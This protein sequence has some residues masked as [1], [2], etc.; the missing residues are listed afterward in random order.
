MENNKENFYSRQIYTYGYETMKNL[1]KLKVLIFGLRGL[2]MEI[3]KNLILSGPKEIYL[4]DKNIIT[5][6]DLG[7]GYYFSE[8]KVNKFCRDEGCI[9]QLSKL[10]SFVEVKILND[11][12]ITALNNNAFNIIIITE[13]LEEEKLY[14]INEICRKNNIGFIYGCT[15][16]LIGFIFVDFGNDFYILNKY[17]REPKTFYINN[18]TNEENAV[19]TVDPA[20]IQDKFLS[21]DSYIIISEVKGMSEINKN[22]PIKVIAIDNNKIS[23]NINTSC[24]NKYING[25]IIKEYFQ[26]EEKNYQSLKY[27]LENPICNIEDFKEDE[28]TCQRH[29]L[30]VGIHKYFNKYKFL[31]EFNNLNQANE[32]FQFSKEYFERKKLEQNELFLEKENLDEDICIN[33]SKWLRAELPPYCNFFGGIMSQEV[34]KYTGKYIPLEQWAWFDFYDTVRNIKNTNRNLLNSRYDEQI[35]IYGL[36]TQKK[37]NNLNIFMIGAGALGCEYLKLFSMMGIANNKNKKITV[38]DNDNIEISNLNRQFLFKK[39]HLGKSK[40]KIACEEIKKMNKNFN[41]EAHQNLVNEDTEII[42]DENFWKSQDI[43]INAVDNNEA[44]K[45]ID[46]NCTLFNKILIDS[47]TEGTK[48]NSQI[49]IPY[50]TKSY[51]DTHTSEKRENIPM[52]TLRL[53]PSNIQQCIE[54]A[55]DKFNEYFLE[56][57]KNLQ[58]FINE[59][60]EYLNKIKDDKNKTEI[61]SKMKTLLE[62]K[63]ENNIGKC[64]ELGKNIFLKLFN[65]DIQKIIDL[66]PQ[67]FKNEDNTYFWSGSKKFPRV[68]SINTEKEYSK[69]FIIYYAKILLNALNIKCRPYLDLNEFYENH[70]YYTSKNEINLEN[71]LLD[72]SRKVKINSLHPE[73]FEKDIDSNNHINFIHIC[74]NLRAKNYSIEECDRL[75]TKLIAGKIIPAV[76]STTSAITGFASSHIYALFY[77]DDIN[78]LKDIR[79]NIATNSYFVLNP[80]EVVG[81]TDIQGKR[82][83]ILSIPKNWTCWDHIEIQGPKTIRQFFEYVKDKY[84]IDVKGMFTRNKDCLIKSKEMLEYYIENAFALIMKKDIEQLRKTL[85]FT[86]NGKNENNEQ[87]RMPIFI[88][89]Y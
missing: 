42:Y 86:I 45:Y 36:D 48:A 1:S 62:I 3:A 67:D 23:I 57:I 19:I 44:R 18:I 83:L 6:F 30:I 56:D 26:R 43:I 66:F 52:C 34:V 61:L 70:R 31:P 14:Q 71:K 88:Y 15:L 74:S 85:S 37:L 55:K 69:K 65:L 89:R 51:N 64:V 9:D 35:A 27:N 16:G 80:P 11:D 5:I 53:F 81:T 72:L 76:S 39:E 59:P 33:L 7:S 29:S 21:N 8:E 20:S 54:W 84:K 24:F 13:L 50:K 17:G 78:L 68:I 12:I 79:F 63:S 60:L 82:G 47:G 75:K 22:T 49:I 38:T 40:S 2:G 25:G 10:N 32:V 58:N 4:Y 46:Y 41:C 77:N 73:I 87:V 28:N